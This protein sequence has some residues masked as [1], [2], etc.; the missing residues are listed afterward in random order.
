MWQQWQAPGLS[1]KST[2][3]IL[4]L[5]S[6]KQLAD[7]Q[8]SKSGF[9][10]THL[11]QWLVI[12]LQGFMFFSDVVFNFLLMVVSLL[13]LEVYFSCLDASAFQGDLSFQ[14]EINSVFN[15]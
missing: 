3:G 8:D 5:L 11:L 6:P 9:A 13:T 12:L 14:K 10:F 7:E 1:H 15:S 4:G 2:R